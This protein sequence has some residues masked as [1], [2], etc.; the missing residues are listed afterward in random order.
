M[1]DMATNLARNPSGWTIGNAVTGIAIDSRST[2]PGSVFIAIPG[3]AHD[4]HQFI[5]EAVDR[6]AIAVV[7]E[8]EA[9]VPLRVPY[10]RVESSRVAAAELSAVFYGFP[11][12]ALSAIGVTGTNG[13]TSV[14]FWL[15]FLL[16]EAGYTAGMISS[17]VNDTGK[18]T[19]GAN[20]TTPESPELQGLLNEMRGIGATHAV[21]EVSSHG[22]VQH[23]VD[24]VDFTMAILTNITRE[25]LDFHGTMER[26]VDAKASLFRALPEASL[27]AVLNAD[28]DYFAVV[29]SQI[30]SPVWTYGLSQGDV[31][32]EILHQ[33]PWSTELLIRHPRFTLQTHVNHPGLYN[34]YN[35]LAVVTAAAELGLS[36]EELAKTIPKLP[37]V[38]GR[39]H[40]ISKGQGPMVV[41][42]YAHTPDGLV[43][44]LN[45][46]RKF[47]RRET[48][49]VF[50]AR[51][52]R[53]RGKR[54]ELGKIAARLADHIILT[55]DS[56]N[57]EDP[58]SILQEIEVGIRET[59][60][61]R[62]FS[63]NLDRA[64][65]I[66]QAIDQ[67]GLDDVVLITGRGPEQ[68]QY[69]GSRRVRLVDS[70]VVEEALLGRG[71]G[72]PHVSGVN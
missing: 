16:R 53:D 5:Q 51:G 35:A 46:V 50:G 13:K 52:G 31:R 6:G 64:E 20:L 70:D 66:R 15:T 62:L 21:V 26:Y 63:V 43:Q 34:V 49:L 22:I 59:N 19:V 40:V 55:S 56:P 36:S 45:T 69:F 12:R 42:D 28:D 72:N 23:R 65:A 44:S 67:A 17:V 57:N 1:G 41:V 11:S 3:S 14:V 39:M 9:M 7:G 27:G 71:E 48:W 29:K 8:R 30:Q 4:G 10:F 32:G 58:E 37:Q 33:G 18:R 38:P 61:D 68:F 25:H 54:P 47:G 60:A 2:R 24:Q